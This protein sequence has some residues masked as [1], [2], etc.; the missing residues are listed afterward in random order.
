M[1]N[2]QEALFRQ[3]SGSNGAA[4]SS[5]NWRIA[6]HLGA[7]E[8]KCLDAIT[9]VSKTIGKIYTTADEH[10][11]PL[12]VILN[13]LFN[14]ALDHGILQLDSSIKQGP[15]GFEDYLHLREDALRTLTAGSIDIEIENE[16]T[17]GHCGVKIHIVDSGNGFDYSTTQNTSLEMAVLGQHG[18]GLALVK[19]MA[20]K[21][22]FSGKG[23]EVTAY[24]VCD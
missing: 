22:I 11:S 5:G 24:Y 23:N 12:C 13:E 9:L 19:S 4:N 21:L 3:L 17:D 8:L 18:R 2:N 20:H 15:D 14:N 1:V 6:I 16:M 10:F 7:D